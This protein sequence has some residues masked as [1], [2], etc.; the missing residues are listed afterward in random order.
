MKN[1]RICISIILAIGI[2]NV[3]PVQVIAQETG[4]AYVQS[5]HSAHWTIYIPI[6]LLVAGAVYFCLSDS[7]NGAN[8]SNPKDALGSIVNPKRVGSAFSTKGS[9]Y[10]NRSRHYSPS[11]SRR[12]SYTKTGYTHS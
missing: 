11:H 3:T 8:T 4:E 1:L 12:T 9:N 10:N 7:G 6:S 2:G 5:G